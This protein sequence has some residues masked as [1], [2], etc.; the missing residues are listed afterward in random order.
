MKTNT[1][2]LALVALLIGFTSCNNDDDTP[3]LLAVETETVSDLYAPQA[4]GM[5]EDITG[6][7]TKFDFE[8]GAITEDENEW[9]IAFRG[10]TILVNGGEAFGFEDEPER[11]GDAAIYIANGT[12]TT[13]TEVDEPLFLQDALEDLAIETGSSNGWYNYDGAQMI[14]TPIAGRTLVVRTTTGRYAKLQIVSYYQGAPETPDAFMDA[15]RYYT[16]DYVYQPNEGETT[17]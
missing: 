15:S 14:I 1:K 11:T 16:F 17:F 12:L 3:P 2:F 5:G 10:T 9:D 4:G 8:T 13:V 6:E 7:F